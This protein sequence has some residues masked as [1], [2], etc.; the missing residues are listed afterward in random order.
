MMR[1]W[2]LLKLKLYDL[3]AMR[4]LLLILLLLPPL[5][6][7]IAG[8]ANLANRQPNIIR[9][10]VVDLEQNEASRAL[11]EALRSNGWSVQVTG[12]DEAGRL[13][14]RQA[15]DGQITLE[16][17]YGDTLKDLKRTRLSYTP[18]E[19]SLATT[20]IREA[21]AAAVLPEY[22]RQ[23]LLAQIETQYDSLGQTPPEDLQAQFADKAAYY[24]AHQARLDVA[25]VGSV[26]AVPSLTYVV[27][28]YSMEVFFLS[29]YAILGPLALAGPDLRRRLASTR[30]GL[31]LDYV[32]SIVALCCLGIVQIMLYSLAMR[33]LMQMP[34]QWTD[35][36]ML[37]VFL[38]LM[39]G[40][41]QLLSLLHPS[42]R[43]YLSLLVLL[44]TSIGGGCFF[45]L[46]GKLIASIGQ[47]LP[48]GWI[49][50]YLK[51]YPVL[52]FYVPLS[53]AGVLL[54]LGY[55]LQ[56]RRVSRD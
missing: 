18:A 2:I 11:I 10:A 20:L 21:V 4:Q 17:G 28:D 41:G 23:S 49:L 29:I 54:M 43:L 14:L 45:Q 39:L 48:Q 19:G 40:F 3:L 26:A 33:G 34:V 38:F 52:P 55:G 46:S 53:L 24:A 47:Y 35:L 56:K 30:S 27:S 15:V 8:S 25:Y 36:V 7:L 6:G 37:A 22:S 13:L 51:G 5:L 42:L 44:L 31:L 9:L 12:A 32:V 50:S 16:S 1:F